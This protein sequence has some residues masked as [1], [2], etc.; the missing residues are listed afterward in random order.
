MPIDE[1]HLHVAHVEGWYFAPTH[2]V[3]TAKSFPEL[4][5]IHSITGRIDRENIMMILQWTRSRAHI[6]IF[7]LLLL[8]PC[9]VHEI[10][11]AR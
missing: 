1:V 8:S 2:D 4:L 11:D 3:S 9:C 10:Q 6:A 7:S 5:S